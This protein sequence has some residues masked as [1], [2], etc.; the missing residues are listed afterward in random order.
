MW[1]VAIFILLTL[2]GIGMLFRGVESGYGTPCKECG[3]STK[4]PRRSSKNPDEYI[5]PECH[6]IES[7]ISSTTDQE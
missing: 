5:C 1:V 4:F 6:E 2:F 3:K 7:R